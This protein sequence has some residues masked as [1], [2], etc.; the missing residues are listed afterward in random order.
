MKT[1]PKRP[2]FVSPK[3]AI[4]LVFVPDNPAQRLVVDLLLERVKAVADDAIRI[5]QVDEIINPEVVS[6][7]GVQVLPTFILL[8]QGVEIWRHSGILESQLL[9]EHVCKQ[10]IQLQPNEARLH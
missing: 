7:F 10:V 6:S 5:T 1:V 3:T 8:K 9:T 4:L 2:I